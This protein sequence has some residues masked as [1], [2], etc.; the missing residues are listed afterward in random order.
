MNPSELIIEASERI[1]SLIRQG[2]CEKAETE[3]NLLPLEERS[4]RRLVLH[5]R[6][7]IL[8]IQGNFEQGCEQ[9][10]EVIRNEGPHILIYADLVAGY[11]MAKQYTKWKLSIEDFKKQLAA[12]EDSLHFINRSRAEIILA[13]SLELTGNIAESYQIFLGLSQCTDLNFRIKGLCNLVRLE[14]QYPLNK[15]FSKHYLLLKTYAF[16]SEQPEYDYDV[17]HSLLLAEAE[18]IDVKVALKTLALIPQTQNCFFAL[19]YYELLDIWLRSD[20]TALIQ[21]KELFGEVEPFTGSDRKLLALARSQPQFDWYTWPNEIPLAQYFRLLRFLL[22]NL[23][24]KDRAICLSQALFFTK[25][26][27]PESRKIWSDFFTRDGLNAFSESALQLKLI[28]AET[29][30]LGN[31]AIRFGRQKLI[32]QMLK[33]VLADEGSS[34]FEQLSRTLWSTALDTY[35][36]DR[37]RQLVKRANNIVK[38]SAHVS[39]FNIR[40]NKVLLASEIKF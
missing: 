34:T 24:T 35:S 5:Y 12:C 31:T 30:S 1:G 13:K 6:A 8:L 4:W 36:A 21:M 17:L 10:H 18:H 29:L 40:E 23:E 28:D 39:I 9:L 25:G 19:G 7:K 16:A 37:I 38:Q 20:Q 15:D 27:S 26:L 14:A 2:K 33:T 3:L 32:L 11:F 22:N